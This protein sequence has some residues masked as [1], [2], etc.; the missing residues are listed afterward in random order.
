M[1]AFHPLVPRSLGLA[2]GMNMQPL[3]TF[4]ELRRRYTAADEDPPQ[5][6]V[7]ELT[8]D[9]DPDGPLARLVIDYLATLGLAVTSVDQLFETIRGLD[10]E[11]LSCFRVVEGVAVTAASDGWWLLFTESGRT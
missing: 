5:L 4:A 10:D 11:D 9:R 7:A 2:K 6:A 3:L 8:A 1:P